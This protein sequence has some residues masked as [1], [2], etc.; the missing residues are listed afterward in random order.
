MTLFTTGEY[1]PV[2]PS[3]DQ[4]HLDSLYRCLA[5]EKR[6]CVLNYLQSTEEDTATVDELVTHV[7][8]QEALAA[9]D[10][11]TVAVDLYHIHLPKLSDIGA[12]DFDRRTQTV[13]Y[14]GFDVLE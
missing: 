5:D 4:L 2:M 13:R 10:R 6:R 3:P 1:E 8:E 12:I 9:S 7:V 11:G 14:R